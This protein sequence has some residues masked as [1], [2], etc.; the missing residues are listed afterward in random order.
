MICEKCG[1]EMVRGYV[2]FPQDFHH[3]LISCNDLEFYVDDHKLDSLH[4]K[5]ANGWYCI[6]CG[7]FLAEFSI[8]P[9]AIYEDG[10]DMDF[11]DETDMLP[12]K[13]CPECGAQV[14]IDYPKCPG[15]G[16]RF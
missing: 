2:S 10:F 15:C 1:T 12:Q 13:N 7:K 11:D 14:D 3:P 9:N 5:S 8:K 6:E 16:C 4:A